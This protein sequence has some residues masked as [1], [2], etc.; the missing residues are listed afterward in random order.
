MVPGRSAAAA[1]G[2]GRARYGARRRAEPGADPGGGCRR[3]GMPAWYGR[4]PRCEPP[5]TP[6]SMS[7]TSARRR[8]PSGD[9]GPPGSGTGSVTPQ[10]PPNRGVFCATD[11]AVSAPDASFVTPRH[12]PPRVEHRRVPRAAEEGSCRPN[13]RGPLP[14]C[15][16]AAPAGPIRGFRREDSALPLRPSRSALSLGSRSPAPR[17]EAGHPAALPLLATELPRVPGS[18]PVR[19]LRVPGRSEA[20]SQRVSG[21]PRAE[22][23]KPG[24]SPYLQKVKNVWSLHLL[25][26][27]CWLQ[28]VL[29]PAARK[30]G[31]G[32]EFP[33]TSTKTLQKK[34]ERPTL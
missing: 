6:C 22:G 32:R 11:A 26:G 24:A 13:P 17:P 14:R 19:S 23:V 3:A 9:P 31:Q 21:G 15:I 12:A 20:R 27:R 25:K 18:G 8:L 7:P 5:R 29:A 30:A 1:E 10:V 2:P 34:A 16:P 4:W 28:G 33:S